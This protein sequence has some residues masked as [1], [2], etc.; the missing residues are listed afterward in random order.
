MIFSVFA[1]M[2]ALALSGQSAGSG[3]LQ[4]KARVNGV[5]QAA[6]AS[7]DLQRA[8]GTH[9]YNARLNERCNLAGGYYVVMKHPVGLLDAA[10]QVEG[11]QISLSPD[12]TETIIAES[13][14][15]GIRDRDLSVIYRPTSDEITFSI[16]LRPKKAVR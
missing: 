16:E 15:A 10:A 2:L 13:D 6:V 11:R 3:A 7:S 12:S 4:M 5:C 14:L 8:G 9:R 1:G